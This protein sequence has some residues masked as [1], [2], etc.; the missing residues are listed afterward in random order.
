MS[1]LEIAPTA[2][3]TFRRNRLRLVT[4]DDPQLLIDLVAHCSQESLF[5]RFHTGMSELR[6]AMAEKLVQTPG[7]GLLNSRGRLVADARYIR[8]LNGEYELSILIC[9]KYQGR[10]LGSA[11]L[12]GMLMQAADDGI[13]TLNADVLASNEPMLA[14]LEKLAPGESLGYEDGARRLRLSLAPMARVA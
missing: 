2:P 9:D 7:L 11:L 3:P 6:P 13:D 5:L 1:Y 8:A 14:L 10:G 4:V 12:S